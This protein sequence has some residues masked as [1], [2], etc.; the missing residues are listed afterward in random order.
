MAERDF[1][2]VLG[3]AKDATPEAIKK[4]YRS[5]ARKYHPDVNQ[6]DKKAEAKF[7]EAQAAYDVLSDAQKRSMYDQFGRAGLEGMMAA[8]PR[9]GGSPWTQRGAGPGAETID[10]S[11]FFGPGAGTAG[12]EGGGGI[13]EELLGRMR[14]S[15]RHGA[16]SG[17]RAGRNLE[18]RLSI[19]FLTAV[20][21]GETTIEI[22]RD[23][24][25]ESLVVK[26]PPG[27]ESGAKLRLRGQ[28]EPGEAGAPNGDLTIEITVEPHPYFTREGRDLTVRVPITVPEALLGARIDVP[29]LDGMKS[30]TVPPGSSSGRKLRLRGQ[31]LPATGDKREGDLFVILEIVVPRTTD[32]ESKRL[33]REFGEHNP[34][35]PREGLW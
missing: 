9:P 4:A 24:K 12:M 32:D 8:G 6:G 14:G 28:G 1:Y 23:H 22:E 11:E 2:E 7:K 15:R 13:F 18:A 26:V 5:L 3:V 29:S 27:I 25:R 35:R 10:F 19:P 16:G 34:L 33:I 20:R 21:G 17:P 30:V 31:G